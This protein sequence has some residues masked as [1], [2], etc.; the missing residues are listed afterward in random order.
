M[1]S[2]EKRREKPGQEK[3]GL[4]SDSEC[5]RSQGKVEYIGMPGRKYKLLYDVKLI[6]RGKVVFPA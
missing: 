2:P 1:V 4:R 3:T 5:Y 6:Q